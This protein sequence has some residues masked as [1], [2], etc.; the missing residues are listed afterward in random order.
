MYG[1]TLPSVSSTKNLGLKW[2]FW[3]LLV[4]KITVLLLAINY[5]CQGLRSI[6][7]KLAHMDQ[8]GLNHKVIKTKFDFRG[9]SFP[10][11]PITF[12]Y[13]CAPDQEINGAKKTQSLSDKVKSFKQNCSCFHVYFTIGR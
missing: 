7:N 1:N 11:S 5:H 2:P 12:P 3:S 13:S 10:L 8:K 4:L 9:L 6:G